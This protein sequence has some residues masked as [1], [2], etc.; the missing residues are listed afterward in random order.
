MKVYHTG[1]KARRQ[2]SFTMCVA[3]AADMPNQEV[4]AA[5]VDDKNVPLQFN[6]EFTHGEAEV[7]DAMGRYLVTRGYVAKTKLLLPRLSMVDDDQQLRLF[8]EGRS[9]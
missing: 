8:T 1:D 7:E 3:P 4:P 5:W 9:P 6:I 2:A